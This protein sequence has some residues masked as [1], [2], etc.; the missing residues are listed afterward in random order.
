[1]A[2]HKIL[3]PLGIAAL[4]STGAIAQD[5][6][7]FVHGSYVNVR[8]NAA[9]DSAV[10]DHV[11]TNTPVWVLGKTEKRCEIRYGEDKQGFVPCGLLGEAKLTLAG[12]AKAIKA[13]NDPYAAMRAF[14]ISPSPITLRMAGRQFQKN[15]L[16]LQQYAQELGYTTSKPP[17]LIRYPIAEFEAMK[18]RLANGVLAQPQWNMPLMSCAQVRQLDQTGKMA[19]KD[20]QDTIDQ[21]S[22]HMW[23]RI[24]FY[25]ADNALVLLG[26]GFHLLQRQALL[27]TDG[28][29]LAGQLQFPQRTA[30]SLLEASQ[31][32]SRNAYIEQL[33]AHFGIRESGRVI[34]TPRWGCFDNSNDCTARYSGAWDIGRYEMQLERPVFTYVIGHDGSIAA[35]QDT[36]RQSFAFGTEGPDADGNPFLDDIQAFGDD[37]FDDKG[38]TRLP[39]YQKV[40]K[41]LFWFY[42][43]KDLNLHQATITHSTQKL[44]GVALFNGEADRITVNQVAVFQIDLNSDG[45]VDFLKVIPWKDD[46]GAAY[47]VFAWIDGQ[48]LPFE[49]DVWAEPPC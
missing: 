6:A 22:R 26:A 7:R 15:L 21:I 36:A 13:E 25:Y 18:A 14:W 33:S 11:T 42:S 41:P 20:Q 2:M 9:P 46:S 8:E 10:I 24:H 48:W 30:D 23:R 43:V 49:A 37:P 5:N 44:K 27:L 35:Y 45:Q 29:R 34:A 39:G 47:F 17:K 38:K 16:S 1:M 31:I 40:K 12:I 4:F 28:C 32:A 19:E 3:L